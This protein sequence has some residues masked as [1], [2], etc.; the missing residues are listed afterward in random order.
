MIIRIITMMIKPMFNSS[1]RWLFMMINEQIQGF[2][3]P[4]CPEFVGPV[5]DAQGEYGRG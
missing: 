3:K 2:F 1:S 4:G 5:G